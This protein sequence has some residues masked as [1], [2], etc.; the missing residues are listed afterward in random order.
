MN[1]RADCREVLRSFILFCGVCGGGGSMSM[2]RYPLKSEEYA[3]SP[4]IGIIEDCELPN[5]VL[6]LQQCF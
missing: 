1:S 6:G 5:W 4:E 3:R 2:F